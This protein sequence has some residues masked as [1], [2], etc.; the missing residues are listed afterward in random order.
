MYGR[1]SLQNFSSDCFYF[2]HEI[3]TES[4]NE[5]EDEEGGIRRASGEGISPLGE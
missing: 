3:E 2:P 1:E 5:I 4:S